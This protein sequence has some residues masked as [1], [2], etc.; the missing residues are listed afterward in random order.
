[1]R[2][3]TIIVL[4][5]VILAI[6]VLLSSMFVVKEWEQVIITE[7]GKPVGE[8]ITQAGLHFKSPFIQNAI[9][10]EKRIL[11]WDGEPK[12]ILTQDKEP[13]RVNTWA[14]W[15]IKDP[16]MF[17]IRTK[18]VAKA[19]GVLDEIIQSTL[20]KVIKTYSLMEVT[21]NSP[22]SLE[23]STD[24]LKVAEEAKGIS[25][26]VGRDKI[27]REIW[28]KASEVVVEGVAKTLIEQY[29]IE[30]VDV[31]IKQ[32]NYYVPKTI[33]AMYGRMRSERLR[34][35]DSY[36]SEGNK[37][38]E[39]IEG[40]IAQE[41]ARIVSEGYKI[42]KEIKGQADAEAL[43]IYAEA[44]GKDHEFYSF[45]KTLETYEKSFNKSTRLILSTDSD[46]FKYLKE[47]LSKEK[48]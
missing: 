37:R 18:T 24:E 12:E 15:R 44:Y 23:Y 40:E 28:E 30:L 3:F 6:I 42:A 41:K 34:I 39:E 17:Y 46:F 29:G 27:V 38:M 47:Y 32:I 13:I 9:Y 43:K 33:E 36:V 21:R 8:P 10:F 25:I 31:Q 16:L 2:Y 26:K 19:Q 48:E 14:R 11:P 4:V 35:R 7:F 5:C 20:Q 1:M 45:I 22:R